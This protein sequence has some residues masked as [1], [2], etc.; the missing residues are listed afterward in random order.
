[1]HLTNSFKT[2][3]YLADDDQDDLDLMREALR[4]VNP[5]VT[6]VEAKNGHDLMTLLTAWSFQGNSSPINLI[7]LD[8]NMPKVNGLEALKAIRA[9]PLLSHIPTVMLSTSADPQE[10]AIAYQSGINGYIQKP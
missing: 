1:M 2:V 9:N 3:I 6:I 4:E 7:L 8:M 5:K 10:I